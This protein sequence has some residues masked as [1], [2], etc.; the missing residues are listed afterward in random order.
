MV[1]FRA[2]RLVCWAIEV[3]AFTTSP[4]SLLDWL[5]WATVPLV[6]CATLTPWPA[7]FEA[8][9]AERAISLID[10]DSSSAL[11]ATVPTLLEIR[12][13]AAE[14]M[15][16]W[17][18]VWSALPANCWETVDRSPDEVARDPESPLMVTMTDRLASSCLL[19]A[20][21][22]SPSSSAAAPSAWTV[23]SPEAEV[24]STATVAQIGLVIDR[25]ITN[26][27]AAPIATA[28]PPTSNIRL[29]DVPAELMAEVLPE[30]TRASRCW[31]RFPIGLKIVVLVQGGD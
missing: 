31:S 5:S 15:L 10:A 8:S 21:A 29:S 28:S 1:A 16:A 4:I 9:P 13:A 23:R 2:S 14:A 18:A 24:S 26:A 30:L 19:S 7:T 6:A 3:I 20:R 25:M 11:A 12:S 17:P 22:M 27:S